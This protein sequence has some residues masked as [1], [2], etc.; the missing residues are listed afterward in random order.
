MRCSHILLDYE[1][2][3]FLIWLFFFSER[4][5]R[6]RVQRIIYNPK[7]LL[8]VPVSPKKSKPAGSRK[9]RS[10]KVVKPSA[11]RHARLCNRSKS[12]DAF[13]PQRSGIQAALRRN[14]LQS[15]DAAV[16][17]RSESVSRN[18]FKGVDANVH[19]K[20]AAKR[21]NRKKSTEHEATAGPSKS[22]IIPDAFVYLMQSNTDLRTQLIKSQA[23]MKIKDKEID[24]LLKVDKANQELIRELRIECTKK[25]Q[26]LRAALSRP[27]RN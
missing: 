3:Y 16:S 20:P 9:S 18:R 14:R 5:L 11:P 25:D 13:T 15:V 4:E 24:V 10:H 8:Y 2:K 22:S 1:V 27:G 12:I 21:T 17:Q 19:E 26:Q 23:D 7:Q 6:P